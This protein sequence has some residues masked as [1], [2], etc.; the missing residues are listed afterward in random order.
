MQMLAKAYPEGL[1]ARLAAGDKMDFLTPVA[2]NDGD[3]ELYAVS[4]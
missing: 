2:G 3:V 4:R 1:A